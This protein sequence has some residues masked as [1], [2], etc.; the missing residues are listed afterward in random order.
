MLKA[1]VCDLFGKEN[2]VIQDKISHLVTAELVSAVSGY[3]GL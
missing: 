2:P 3:S 1:V